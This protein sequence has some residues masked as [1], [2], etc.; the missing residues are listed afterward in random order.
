M[1]SILHGHDH[2]GHRPKSLLIKPKKEKLSKKSM[3]SPGRAQK[4]SRLPKAAD[5]TPPGSPILWYDF[6]DLDTLYQDIAKTTPVTAN[7][8]EISAVTSKGSS[9]LDLVAET[10]GAGFVWDTAAPSPVTGTG[11]LRQT[12]SN[13]LESTTDI[14]GIEPPYSWLLV[15]ATSE[16]VDGTAEIFFTTEQSDTTQAIFY[17]NTSDLNFGVGGGT[18]AIEFASANDTWYAAIGEAE[19]TADIAIFHNAITGS[20]TVEQTVNEIA[21]NT[22]NNMCVGAFSTAKSNIC[23]GYIGD[24]IIY[25]TTLTAAEVNLLKTYTTDKYGITWA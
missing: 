17:T 15:Y 12:A 25:S 2:A 19:S 1:P 3:I 14:G 4:A 10:E 13:V 7:G 11:V 21:Q 9:T 23:E 8:Q 24:L 22:G 6:T 18:T 16:N 5:P 20:S